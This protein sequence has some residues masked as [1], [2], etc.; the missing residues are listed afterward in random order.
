MLEYDSRD[1]VFT[2]NNGISAAVQASLFREAFGGDH[3]FEKY[4]TYIKYFTQLGNPV[5]LGLRG[6]LETIDGDLSTP[7]YEYPFISMRGIPVMRYQGDTVGVAEAEIRW[8]YTFRWSLV[9]FGFTYCP[10][11]CPLTLQKLASAQRTLSEDGVEPLPRIVLVSVD[12]ERD[13][14]EQL[15]A[16]L[17]G[18][19]A[20]AIGITG[21]IDEIRK[22]T[23]E[24]GIFFEKRESDGD[25][26]AV[27]HSSVVLVI[28][29]EGRFHALFSSPHD[30]ENFVHDLP[31]LMG[32]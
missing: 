32:S 2:P 12:P 6:E 25:Y 10:D 30:T 14:P 22:L 15:G 18:F 28:D 1:T 5:V 11:V 27:D 24:L 19:R 8:N 31:L 16:Y 3:D 26:Y 21:E 4:K 29:P 7:Y 23:N 20:D 13:T 17:E 9:F